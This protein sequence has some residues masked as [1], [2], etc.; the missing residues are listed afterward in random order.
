MTQER[1]LTGLCNSQLESEDKVDIKC[2][3]WYTFSLAHPR[4]AYGRAP[5]RS[6]AAQEDVGCPKARGG[7]LWSG[8]QR[9]LSS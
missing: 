4:Q 5:M 8:A 7:A 6:T 9:T 1:M 2:K 3:L